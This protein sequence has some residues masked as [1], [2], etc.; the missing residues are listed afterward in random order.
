MKMNALVSKH[1]AGQPL[2]WVIESLVC[3]TELVSRARGRGEGAIY[4]TCFGQHHTLLLLG[5]R[6]SCMSYWPCLTRPEAR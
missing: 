5:A 3:A 2:R 4:K 6:R 1:C